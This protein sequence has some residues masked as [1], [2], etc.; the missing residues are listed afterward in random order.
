[1]SLADCLTPWHGSTLR[2]V[3]AGARIDVLDF[4][5]AGRG[6]AS[7]WNMPGQPTLYLA[8]DEGVLVAEWG[9]HFVVNRTTA[10][11]HQTVERAVYT[12]DLAL[13]AVLDLRDP[14]VLE[15]LSI[16]QAPHCFTDLAFARATAQFVRSTTAAQ[17]LLVPSMCF[18]DDLSRWCLVVFL[19]KLPPDPRAYITAVTPHR[20]IRW[21]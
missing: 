9:R 19:D 15:T 6:P 14:R 10:L 2:H 4:R 13:D 11:R 18:L 3:P 7:R 8:G 16:A 21:G 20:P 12:L 17:A 1:V 5:Y